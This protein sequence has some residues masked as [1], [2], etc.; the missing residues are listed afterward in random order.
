VLKKQR[1]SSSVE[2]YSWAAHTLV[3]HAFIEECE[4]TKCSA[5]QTTR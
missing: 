4:H 5:A 3:L 2:K 1:V